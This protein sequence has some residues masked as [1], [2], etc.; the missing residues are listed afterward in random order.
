LTLSRK[1]SLNAMSQEMMRS[2]EF[3]LGELGGHSGL[4]AVII[5]GEGHAFCAG[6]DLKEFEQALR[7]G[8]TTLIDTLRYNQGV[9]QQVEDLPVPVIGAVNDI[10]VA[11]GLELLLCCELSLQPK[12]Q[13]WATATRAT[14][15][16]PA[17]GATVRLLERV[18]PSHAAQLFYTAAAIDVQTLAAWGLVNEVVPA[19]QLMERA[20]EIAG[21][22]CTNSPEAVRHI[23]HLIGKR[24]RPRNRDKRIDSELRCFAKHVHG[25]YLEKGLAA[26]VNKQKPAF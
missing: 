21:Q 18:T 12:V 15:F 9:L 20:V 17:G 1:Q 2:L 24:S 7:T 5:T 10:A 25:Q 3:R 14:P 26:F 4:R 22:I 8:G 13:S 16:V 23:K 6:G 19:H 11:G